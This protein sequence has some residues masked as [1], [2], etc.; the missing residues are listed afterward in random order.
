MTTLQDVF[1]K[2]YD[3]F[4]QRYNLSPVQA[5]A[6]HNIMHSFCLQRYNLS[7]VQ[8]KAVHDIIQCRTS[9]LGGHVYECGEC[10]HSMILYNSCRNRHCNICQSLPRAVWIDK[11]TEDILN[12]PYFHVVFTLPKELHSL[13]YQNQKELYKLM[14]KAVSETL[15]ELSKDLCA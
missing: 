13:V 1:E 8:A 10:G 6:V 5:K 11:R 4:K 2:F 9:A 15:S 3:K 7:P 14:Y 12:A